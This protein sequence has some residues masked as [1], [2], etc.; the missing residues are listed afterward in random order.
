MAVCTCHNKKDWIRLYVTQSALLDERCMNILHQVYNSGPSSIKSCTSRG[1][2]GIETSYGVL[3]PVTA[4]GIYPKR[5]SRPDQYQNANQKVTVQIPN[6]GMIG[7]G[8]SSCYNTSK[9]PYR[10]RTHLGV[11]VGNHPS[12]QVK[13]VTHQVPWNPDTTIPSECPF[14][15]CK[16]LRLRKLNAES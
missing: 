12:P 8:M 10:K 16:L 14:R 13:A 5:C 7:S 2:K 11:Y 9:P 6:P 3:G 1:P 15:H 4:D